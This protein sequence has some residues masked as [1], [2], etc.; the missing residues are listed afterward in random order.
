[1]VVVDGNDI[2]LNVIDLLSEV[3]LSKFFIKTIFGVPKQELFLDIKVYLPR[4]FLE[5]FL[6]NI[7]VFKLRDAGLR[8]G[9]FKPKLDV[10]VGY[11]C[12]V[13]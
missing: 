7:H 6:T 8:D 5:Y 4:Y 10:P 3:D 2:L 12:L 13:D 1:M 11:N 9:Y